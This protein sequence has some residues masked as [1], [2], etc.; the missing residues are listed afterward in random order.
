MV[1]S[2]SQFVMLSGYEVVPSPAESFGGR[3]S[4]VDAAA[5]P[6]SARASTVTPLVI[7]ILNRI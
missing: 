1:T 4:D 5:H 6:V 3:A 7:M 2:V